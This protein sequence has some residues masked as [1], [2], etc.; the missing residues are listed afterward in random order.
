M[1][2]Q[3]EL[4]RDD[5]PITSS[6]TIKPDAAL[7]AEAVTIARPARELY[8]FWRDVANLAGIMENI[9]SIEPIDD[10]RSPFPG[11]AG[12][13]ARLRRGSHQL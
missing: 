5:A 11:A 12:T 6:K 9:E 1:P 8:D 13:C 10:K 3:D 7:S 4:V 2:T